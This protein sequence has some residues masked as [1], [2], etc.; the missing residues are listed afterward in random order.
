[1]RQVILVIFAVLATPAAA[2]PVKKST[3]PNQGSKPMRTITQDGFRVELDLS[4]QSL[5]LSVPE[6]KG[7]SHDDSSGKTEAAVAPTLAGVASDQF[8]SA[9]VLAQKAKQFDDGLYAAVELAAEQGAGTFA[10]KAALLRS[11]AAGLIQ[12]PPTQSI[13]TVLAGCKLGKLPI[14]LS[15][16]A[17]QPVQQAVDDFLRDE[18]RSKPIAFYT[19]TEQL[20]S[21]FQQ[22]RML[23]TELKDKA[24]TEA[25]VKVL[26]G[27][28]QARATYESYL[29]LVSRLTNPPAYPDLREQLAASD[30]DGMNVPAK[31]ICFFPPSRAHETELVKKLYGNRP[32]PENFS[33]IDE[34]I[35]RIQAGDLKL[36]PTDDSGWYDYQTWALEPLVIPERMPEAAHLALDATYRKQLLELFKGILALTRETHIKQLEIPAAGAA[37]PPRE[38]V[39]RISPELNAEPV[40][41]YYFRRAWSY[42]FIR[43]V[44]E[45]TFG[46]AA[47]DNMHRLTAAG[48]VRPSLVEELRTMESLFY[49]AHVSVCRQLGVAP[50]TSPYIGSGKGNDTDT[51]V[52]TAWRG[53]L[54]SDADI[55]QDSRMM[56]P[57]F[58]DV[59]RKKTKVW[60]FLGWASRPLKVDFDR[61]P[62]ATIF[63]TKGMQVQAGAAD[64]PR[65]VFHDTNY[66]L[67]YPVTAEVYVTKILNRDEFRAHCDQHKTRSAILANLK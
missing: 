6:D 2:M 48:S 63:D 29:T 66:F 27:E 12:Q 52:F 54:A 51:N 14:E 33:L 59:Q 58:Y 49:G 28:Q 13:V 5:R 41:S 38:V 26:K 45:G 32:I 24:G 40:A 17:R 15:A 22:D 11:V 34:M 20:A 35:K 44:I 4:N 18:L 60:A 19:W 37:M 61:P 21:I 42:F 43:K 10:G 56:V 7:W 65:L 62:A 47:L 9:S 46:P 39:I 31:G 23:Q 57:V 8:V 1:M 3:D 36:L 25:L 55:G 30:R 53:N 16:A 50:T 67:A 64:A